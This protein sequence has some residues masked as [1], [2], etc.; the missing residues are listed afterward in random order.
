MS[1]G[2]HAANAPAKLAIGM[3]RLGLDRLGP[4]SPGFARLGLERMQ[5][6]H[7]FLL[8]HAADLKV[9]PQQISVH[10]RSKD[11]DI[12]LDERLAHGRRDLIAIDHARHVHPEIRRKPCIVLQVEEQLA[13]PIVGHRMCRSTNRTTR[14]NRSPVFDKSGAWPAWRSASIYSSAIS[15]P[16]LR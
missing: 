10:E 2:W 1:G 13:Q 11:R 16:A 7:E 3:M 6:R 14:S 12:V 9:K 5:A 8:R 15:P 4:G